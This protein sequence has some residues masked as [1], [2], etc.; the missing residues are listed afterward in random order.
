MKKRLI[1]R[2]RRPVRRRTAERGVALVLVLI[3]LS[4]MLLLGLAT[5]MTSITEV[6]VGRNYKLSIEAFD[7]AD[8]G[9]SH[10]YQLI[11][12]MKGDFTYVLRGQDD[13]MK[14]GDEF[15]NNGKKRTYDDDGNIVDD[16][17]GDNF[18]P[19]MFDVVPMVDCAIDGVDRALYQ[20][21]GTHFYELIAYDN[22]HDDHSWI[23]DTANEDNLD[24]LD[25]PSIDC[26]S[27][28]L[29]RS[30]GYVMSTTITNPAD[31]FDLD[32][33]IASAVVDIVIG[34]VPYPA[35]I[36]NNDL[37]VQNG[38]EIRGTYGAVHA[39]DNLELGGGSWVI[40][41]SA[42][43]ANEDAD[44]DATG[45]NETADNDNVTGFNGPA[46]ELFIPDLNPFD[47]SEDA[48]YIAKEADYIVVQHD[49][50][51]QERTALLTAM[52]ALGGNAGTILTGARLNPGE[53]LFIT[54]NRANPPTYALTDSGSAATE[55]FTNG[56]A[57]DEEFAIKVKDNGAITIENLPT[58]PPDGTWTR[59]KAVFVLQQE[60]Q[61]SYIHANNQDGQISIM[62]NGSVFM[63]GNAKVRPA[64]RIATPE[65][66][67][68]NLIDLLVMA[69]EDLKMDGTAGADDELEGVMYCHEQFDLSG[70]GYI[71]GQVVGYDCNLI[72]DATS[73]NF[74]SDKPDPNDKSTWITT[75]PINS[76]VEIDSIVRGNFEVN[77]SASN[78]YIGDFAQ[79]AW[80]QLRDVKPKEHLRPEP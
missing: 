60:A 17:D 71:T 22:A 21:D 43:F 51:T 3:F 14:T 46:S 76:L 55:D 19:A 61:S 63:N 75:D 58:A 42:T 57:S 80:R 48:M 41:Q 47:I 37:T 11:D 12:N 7:V 30:V 29:I 70:S 74:I 40:E 5:T 52:N 59:G 49:A 23:D 16:L 26:D 66:P 56:L 39:N 53:A 50:G 72:W 65:A 77:H 38:V 69:G 79:V 45:A 10:A 20:I 27:R 8:A 1:R 2:L 36:T 67:P 73:S 15:E 31:E 28:I 33:V 9:A 32:N 44:D 34:L 4:L 62:T 54:N 18:D 6:S 24:D 64:I 68:W 25:D 13:E 78:G 35:I